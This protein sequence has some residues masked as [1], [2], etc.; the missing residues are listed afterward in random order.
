MR[1]SYQLNP[2]VA[3]LRK[4]ARATGTPLFG[5]FELT[6]RCNLDCKMCYVHTLDVSE[7]LRT[8]LSMQQWIS[9]MDDAFDHGMLFALLT[10]GECLL[11]K[12]FKEIYLHLYNK[13]VFI[14]VNTNAVL[15]D[16]DYADFFAKYVPERIQITLYGSDNDGYERVTGYRKFDQTFRALSLLKERNL[17]VEIAVTPSTWLKNDFR[18]I[19]LRIKEIGLPYKVNAALIEPRDNCQR[20]G[21]YLSDQDQIELIRQRK[22]LSNIEILCPEGDPP[23]AGC[24][25]GNIIKGMPCNAGTIRFVINS[26]G[27]M[28]PCTAID[29]I[30][31]SAL[32]NDFSTCWT[33]IRD[34][35]SK[36]LQPS[37]C[38]NCVYKKYCPVCPAVR[39]QGLFSGKVDERLCSLQQ[40]KY[41]AGLI[42]L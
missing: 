16:E 34:Q 17:P 35:M 21:D 4:Q 26:R 11:R 40:K 25:D 10:G 23:A 9:I 19:L 7:A 14:S 38:Q 6:S 15:I 3:S 42:H 1:T 20:S 33:Y 28:M 39:Y 2:A 37:E 22:E 12:D 31:I 29:Y 24:L 13:G 36:V 18:N 41:K 5:A 32:E 8:E 30:A 27:D